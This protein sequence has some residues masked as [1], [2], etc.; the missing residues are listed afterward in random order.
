MATSWQSLGYF[1]TDAL[2]EYSENF[3]LLHRGSPV[4]VEL[5]G[6][7]FSIHISSIHDSGENRENEDEE[8]IQI[9]KETIAHQ[10]EM[11]GKGVSAIFIGFFPDGSVFTGWEPEYVFSQ[12]PTKGG[13]SVYDRLSNYGKALNDGAA[14]RVFTAKNLG[15]KS[16]TISLRTNAL[17][18]Y[19]ENWDELHSIREEEKLRSLIN[20]LGEDIG[21][22]KRSGSV[23]TEIEIGGQRRKVVMKREAYPR[24]PKFSRDVLAA[25]GWACCVCGRQL[26]L[27]QAA[28]IVPHSNPACKDDVSNGLAL[29]VEHHKLYDDALLIPR[30]G[31]KL[32]LN[33]DRVE[34][35]KNIRQDSGLDSLQDLAAK[36]FKVP[37]DEKCRPN[38]DFL[39]K[40]LRIRLGIDT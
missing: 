27:V 23:E 35:L 28:H 22:E 21:S 6:K 9:Q 30:A 31:T 36:G 18:L 14:L 39:E 17:G 19:L 10:R 34:H 12:N 11:A 13:G 7:K 33:P 3:R 4:L 1:L 32:H 8:R 20:R 40:G 26:G 38:E 2:S 37:D 5:N 24:N 15:R 16:A 29:C 25:Y